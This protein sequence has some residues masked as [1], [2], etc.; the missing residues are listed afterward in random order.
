MLIFFPC[1]WPFAWLLAAYP[2]SRAPA[3]EADRPDNLIDFAAACR[4]RSG[5]G[6]RRL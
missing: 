2:P 3:V 1:L 4:R 5:N 6:P